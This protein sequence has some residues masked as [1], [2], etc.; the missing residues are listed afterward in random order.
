[1]ITKQVE[2]FKSMAAISGQRLLRRQTT[3]YK[4]SPALLSASSGCG[5]ISYA[6]EETPGAASFH[7]CPRVPSACNIPATIAKPGKFGFQAGAGAIVHTG[8][9]ILVPL[10]LTSSGSLTLRCTLYQGLSSSI[11]IF[12]P[13]GVGEAAAVHNDLI[14]ASGVW[15]LPAAWFGAAGCCARPGRLQDQNSPR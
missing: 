7:A 4:M 11:S 8:L 15:E 2:H 1:M 14:S 9:Q 10:D 5:H 3:I 6:K 12:P 13:G